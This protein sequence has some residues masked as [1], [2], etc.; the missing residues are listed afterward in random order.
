LMLSACAAVANIAAAQAVTASCFTSF[1]FTHSSTEQT[2]CQRLFQ[3][4]V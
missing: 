2:A 1:I 4:N 3:K